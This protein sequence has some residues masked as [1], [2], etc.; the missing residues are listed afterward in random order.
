MFILK[1]NKLN[2]VKQKRKLYWSNKRTKY[3]QWNKEMRIQQSA[4]ILLSS[5]R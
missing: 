2:N 4:V 1:L 5:K 3:S